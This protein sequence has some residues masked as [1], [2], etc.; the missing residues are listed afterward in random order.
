MPEVVMKCV[1]LSR[2]NLEV[3]VDSLK[4]YGEVYGPVKVDVPYSFKKIT[5]IKDMSLDYTRTMIP[6]KTFFVKLEEQLFAFD[7]TKGKYEETVEEE[8][9]SFLACTHVIFTR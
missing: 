5:N 2:E 9:S 7:E 3:F 6:P 1:K 4:K 8:K